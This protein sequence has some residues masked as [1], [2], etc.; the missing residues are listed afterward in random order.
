MARL[1][2]AMWE[3]LWGGESQVN[4]VAGMRISRTTRGV[5]AIAQPGPGGNARATGSVFPVWL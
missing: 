5:S 1:L 3:K 4:Q 2:I